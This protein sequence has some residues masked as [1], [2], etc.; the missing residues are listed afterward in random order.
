MSMFHSGGIVM[1]AILILSLV[2]LSIFLERL[3]H[4]HRAQIRTDDFLRGIFNV[5]RAGNRLE[6]VT[7]C[8]ETPGPVAKLVHAAL[9]HLDDGPEMIDKAIKDAGLLEI[10]RLERRLPLLAS[11]GALAP[12]LGLLGTILGL[13]KGLEILSVKAPLIHSGD[14]AGGLWEALLTTAFGLGV[15]IPAYA[16]YNLLLARV[17]SLLLY[18]EQAARETLDR[19]SRRRP[20]ESVEPA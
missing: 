10:P 9:L 5:L 8:E 16:G 18:M 19:L 4:Y 6:A 14:L 17:D 11:I 3:F 2:G 15:A 12:M 20:V 1:V 13:L 7:L